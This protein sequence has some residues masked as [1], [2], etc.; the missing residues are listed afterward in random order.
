M[1]LSI[2]YICK[3]LEQKTIQN[4]FSLYDSSDFVQKLIVN[5]KNNPQHKVNIKGFLG[6]GLSILAGHLYDR[7]SRP[8]ILIFDDKEEAAYV[9]ND[10]ETLFD[11]DQILFFP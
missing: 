9:L 7:V 10:L 11:K 1:F 3:T 8:T 4:V 5:F 6:S 2:D